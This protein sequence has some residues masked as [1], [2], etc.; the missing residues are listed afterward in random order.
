M[1]SMTTCHRLLRTLEC[2]KC[3]RVDV[4]TVVLLYYIYCGFILTCWLNVNATGRSFHETRGHVVILILFREA[5]VLIT[6][7][8]VL[9]QWF[10]NKMFW[11]P[12]GDPE[13]YIS[14]SELNNT[15]IYNIN[16]E[17]NKRLL[18][19]QSQYQQILT[20]KINLRQTIFIENILQQTDF[21]VIVGSNSINVMNNNLVQVYNFPRN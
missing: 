18:S 15:M 7:Q 11:R 16:F 3:G 12:S 20:T 21:F 2:I 14:R 17:D 4:I 1:L 6:H 19:L 5:R 10:V 13:E 9:K 8:P